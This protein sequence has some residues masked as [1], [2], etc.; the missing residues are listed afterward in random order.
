MKWCIYCIH[1]K[2]VA[3][4]WRDWIKEKTCYESSMLNV[5]TGRY[6]T[7]GVYNDGLQE[8]ILTK[9][10]KRNKT[11]HPVISHCSEDTLVVLKGMKKHI[12]ECMLNFLHV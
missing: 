2:A 12:M 3:E 8:R 7:G 9:V 5:L 6:E 4:G 1:E 11:A 10:F